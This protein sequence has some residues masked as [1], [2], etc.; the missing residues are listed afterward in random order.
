M[1]GTIRVRQSHFIVVWLVFTAYLNPESF[2]ITM[3]KWKNLWNKTRKMRSMLYTSIRFSH[4]RKNEMW[5]FCANLLCCAINVNISLIWALISQLSKFKVS[6]LITNL[7]YIQNTK[8]DWAK[9]GYKL[10]LSV[11]GCICV[12]AL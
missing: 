6:F 10:H 5:I 4:F 8:W 9:N 7:I 12:W 2:T 11:C 3:R 1:V